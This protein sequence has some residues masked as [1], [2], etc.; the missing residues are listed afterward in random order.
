MNY[1]RF[2]L[3]LLLG[4][5]F[6]GYSQVEVLDTLGQTPGGAGYHVNYD[7]ASQHLF[8][9][10]GTSIW[11][12]DTQDTSNIHVVAR[13]PLLG[14]VNETDLYG[15]I[16][17]VA[18]THDGVWALDVTSDTLSALSH[19]EMTG[20]SAAYDLWRTNDTLYVADGR[21]VRMLHYDSITSTFT[22]LDTFGPNES[23]CV[24]RKGEYI[25]V[26]ARG[27]P[28][29]TVMVYH[30]TNLEVP[31]A[32]WQSNNVWNLQDIQWGD[33]QDDIIYVCGG[34]QNL[35]FTQSFFYA[36]H[37]E[38]P[39]LS[40]VDSFSVPGIIGFAQ[41]NINNMDSQNDTLFISTGAG[42]NNLFQTVVPVYD[43][44]G[45]PDTAMVHLADIRPGL[46]HFDVARMHGT[47]YLAMSSEWLG[48]LI[49]DVSQLQPEDTLGL[50]ET[51]GWCQRAYI[52]GDTLWACM[53][54]Y[55]LVAYETDSLFYHAG[56]MNNPK[57]LHIFTQF[58]AD[59]AFVNDSLILLSN[60]EI[61]NL[62][63]WFLGGYPEL[64]GDIGFGCETIR[65]IQTNT[66]TRVIAGLG[67]LL[68]PLRQIALYDPFDS[69]HGYPLLDI[70]STNSDVN[71][72]MISG[73]TV[74]CGKKAGNTFYLA[75]FR[76]AND[77]LILIDTV[78]A[79]GEINGISRDGS[80]LAVSCGM[81]RFAWYY[82]DGNMLVQMGSY[83]DWQINPVGIYVKN[84]LVYIADK[85]YG[86][87][88]FRLS[89]PPQATLVAECPGTGGWTNMFGS[90]AVTLGSDGG[91]YLSDFMAGVILI[92]PYDSTLV[93]TETNPPWNRA[94][95]V[96]PNPF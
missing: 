28:K 11:I 52:R 69:I 14:L 21:Q 66:G 12:Y 27:I 83:F 35:L 91:I 61:Y 7:S 5:S 93:V 18:A 71:G 19:Y 1:F 17:F 59:V 44:T 79:P 26:G 38:V 42:L 22:R 53:R 55:G 37:L 41:A 9:G 10:C 31:V 73:D 57:I 58:V 40:A 3:I 62:S 89:E 16:L 56:Y 33:L 87:R 80:T 85:F 48:V 72:L 90:T 88:I 70:D 20:D 84:N 32:M 13:R 64:A 43:A 77:S 92:E 36:L 65:A 94:V 34:A 6:A 25:A 95:T 60:G 49:S 30:F 78:P 68:L 24:S 63:P 67:N 4:Y 82:I 2:S 81:F 75:M 15:D 39:F 50:L 23:F 86:L 76:V 46:W 45:L 74:F 54:G 51:G 8:V 96:V 29:G 47:P